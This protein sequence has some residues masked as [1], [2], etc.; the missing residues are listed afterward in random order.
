[1]YNRYDN[2]K[3]MKGYSLSIKMVSLRS[4]HLK[5][6]SFK[7]GKGVNLQMRNLIYT[8]S[9][10]RPRLS[11]IVS[12]IDSMCLLYNVIKIILCICVLPVPNQ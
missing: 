10:R 3:E 5:N 7:V 1:M 9:I 4:E 11:T 8:S 12:D 2:L 6:D